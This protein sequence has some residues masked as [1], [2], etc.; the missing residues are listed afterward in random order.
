MYLYVPFI[1]YAI[2]VHCGLRSVLEEGWKAD[3]VVGLCGGSSGRGVHG[4]A[5]VF[6]FSFGGYAII[7]SE[8]VEWIGRWGGAVSWDKREMFYRF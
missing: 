2:D 1:K 8:K 3:V 4:F 5:E 6:V 7:K